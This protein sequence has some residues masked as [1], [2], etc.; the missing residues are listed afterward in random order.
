[1]KNWQKVAQLAGTMPAYQIAEELGIAL[2]TVTSHARELGISLAYQK[3]HWT[4]EA[5]RQLIE[6][7]QSGLTQKAIGELTGRSTGAV[8]LQL[9]KLKKEGKL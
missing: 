4:D 8:R 3:L 2:C 1:M 9:A 7:R 6:L 5:N